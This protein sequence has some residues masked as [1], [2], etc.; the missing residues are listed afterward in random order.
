M[1][2]VTAKVIADSVSES[3]KRITT[4]ELE[5]HRFLLPEFNTH[6][7]ISKNAASSRA[8]PVATMIANIEASPAIPLY[9]GK[10]QAGM[11]A[12]EECDEPIV[13]KGG[14]NDNLQSFE[15]DKE[16][17]WKDSARIACYKARLMA[18]AGYH[19]QIVNRLTE[20]F[21]MIKVVATATEWDN[22]FWLRKNADSQPE[23]RILAEKMWEARQQSEPVKLTSDDWHTPYFGAGYWLKDCGI[24][25]EDAL[26]ISSSCCAQVSYRKTDDS[27]EKAKM[28]YARLVESEPVH[29]S[30]FEHCA[31]PVDQS[32]H[33]WE[34]DGVTSFHK[35]LGIMSGNFAGWIQFRQLINNNT[36]WEYK[37]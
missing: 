6:R 27:L 11:S 17:W 23:I 22:F 12:K 31:K 16:T 13:A 7:M 9:W 26:A 10:N 34:Q 20:P 29:S 37:E 5:F 25:L 18:E 32:K 19:K 35:R 28:V 21:Q 36:C 2:N 14:I 15:F 8:I 33:D 4:F 24:P 1:S 30:P 3:G